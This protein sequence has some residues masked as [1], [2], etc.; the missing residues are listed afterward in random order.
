VHGLP[1]G[2][3]AAQQQTNGSKSPTSPPKKDETELLLMGDDYHVA[4]F[5][6]QQ[7]EANNG[8]GNASSPLPQNPPKP[9][10]MSKDKI[11][12]DL[13]RRA[14]RH[15]A[16][17][18]FWDQPDYKLIQRCIRG[19]LD[20]EGAVGEVDDIEIEWT[21]EAQFTPEKK[22]KR[23]S[24][25]EQMPK[26][27]FSA[28]NGNDRMMDEDPLVKTELFE[29][30]PLSPPTEQSLNNAV[31]E[32]EAAA[33]RLPLEQQFRIA[34][35]EYHAKHPN[36]APPHVVLRDWMKVAI[37][38]LY[39]D[40]DSKAYE[41]GGHRTSTDGYRREFYL[42]LLEKCSKWAKLFRNFSK[43]EYLGYYD[44]G[45]VGNVEEGEVQPIK[46]KKV[47]SS[48]GSAASGSTSELF[49][50]DLVAVSKVVFGLQA[51]SR[52]ERIKSFAPP[53]LLSFGPS[54]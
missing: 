9:L 16:N 40:W 32:Q 26:W 53:P 6:H 52:S 51:A 33:R 17:L 12:I 42:E 27:E 13:L 29:N 50:D 24:R 20:E 21:E 44:D 38:L 39:Q 46:K 18:Q 15:V 8:A 4:M 28:E 31:P 49:P 48:F 41:K 10:D 19:F 54:R 7:R 1:P 11:K 2:N 37:P 25:V 35:M 30:I 34:Q 22:R 45:S 36:T 43:K 23:G 3:N 5:K 47:V 14:F